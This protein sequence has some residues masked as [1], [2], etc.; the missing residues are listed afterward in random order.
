MQ[1]G[2]SGISIA[3][4]TPSGD[5]AVTSKPVADLL[6]GLVMTAVDMA[7]L[8]VFH[9][10]GQ[11]RRQLRALGDP[12]F[13]RDVR[14]AARGTEWSSAPVIWLGM[15]WTS[16]P[17]IATFSTCMPRQI[18]RNGMPLATAARDSAISNSSRPVFRGLERAVRL[19][20]RRAAGRRRRRPSASG[21]RRAPGSA[22]AFRAP[23]TTSTGSP[24]AR[25]MDS[26]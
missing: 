9:V 3:S 10:I 2:A 1:N 11:Q 15:S 12:H 26:T 6:D 20:R 22:P 25:R 23:A 21:R 8:A 14:S 17:P 18:A 24:P 7:G 5:V 16:V 13:M 4:T 19:L